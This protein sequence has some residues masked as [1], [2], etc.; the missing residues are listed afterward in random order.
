MSLVTIFVAVLCNSLLGVFLVPRLAMANH[1]RTLFSR[2]VVVRPEN[3]D[4]WLGAAGD[5]FAGLGLFR[6]EDARPKIKAGSR[7]KLPYIF[8]C[9][10]SGAT[11]AVWIPAGQPSV[12]ILRDDRAAS[13][14]PIL[15]AWASCWL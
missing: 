5:R 11:A 7:R 12:A 15:L 8:S 13:G 10:R 6:L 4:V 1:G 2:V 9:G 14:V 3:G